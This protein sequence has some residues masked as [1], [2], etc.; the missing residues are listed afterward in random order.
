MYV[1]V[2]YVVKSASFSLDMRLCFSYAFRAVERIVNSHPEHVNVREQLACT[3]LHLAANEGEVEVARTLLKIV[4]E[5]KTS[6]CTCIYVYT[7]VVQL[8]MHAKIILEQVSY[9]YI[10]M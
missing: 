4:R 5:I 2:P 6:L 8:Y 1:L 7:I 3:P 10:Y 9:T